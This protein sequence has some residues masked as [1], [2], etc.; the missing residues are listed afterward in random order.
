[1]RPVHVGCSGWGYA[2]WRERFYPPKL[3]A[4]GWLGAYAERFGTVE[5]NATFYRLMKPA[6]VE[7]WLEQVPG[8][9]VFAIKA[10]RYLTHIKRLQDIGPGVERFYET[11]EP[12][13]RGK[14][15]GPVLWQL[16]ESFHRDDARLEHA[17]AR[18]PPGRHAFE[19]RH[20]SWFCEPVY[21]LLRERGAALAVG[22]HPE[23][24]FQTCERTADWRY[25]RLHHG[26]R[27]RRGN[28]SDRELETWARRVHDWRGRDEVFVYFNND[29][30]A[31]APRNARW[32]N[33]RLAELAGRADAS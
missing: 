12:L 22:D 6:S 10:S 7:R 13:V 11:I 15:L 24:P 14:R 17:L 29:W 8:R 30:E 26:A 5:V 3:P 16:P 1:M 18:L 31:F 28:Y 4:H 21:A 33:N 19:L 23:R 2:A 20:A 32:L 9:F 27:G 25:V